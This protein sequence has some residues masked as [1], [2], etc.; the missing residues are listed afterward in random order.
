[1]M[2]GE[3]IIMDRVLHIIGGDDRD[4][5]L[6]KLLEEKGFVIKLW[7]FDKLGYE[8]F[9]LIKLKE[10]LIKSD[11]PVLIFPLSG[12]K[13]KGEVRSKYSSKEIIIDEDF[14]KILPANSQIIIGFARQWFKDYCNIYQINLLEVA[15]DDELAILNSIPSAE[16]AI[17]MAMEN[18]EITIHNSNSL[19]IGLGRCGMTLARL[20]KGLDSKVYVYARN[21]VNLARAFEM[22]FTPVTSQELDEILLKMDFIYNTAPSL[23]LP[24]EKLDY[25]LNCE[26]IIDIAS[27]PGGV[28]FDYAKEKGIKA[29][30]APGLPGIVAPKTAAKIL[31]YVYSKFLGGENYD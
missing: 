3:V 31:A 10:Q 19:V 26:V 21:K 7:G 28:D 22:G 30:L 13:V 18:S 1:M 23:V 17:Q 5:Y 25:C 29:L 9:D 15:E 6:K 2:E 14:F 16:G 12:T 27:A 11:Y 24:K 8:E 4:I 20:L